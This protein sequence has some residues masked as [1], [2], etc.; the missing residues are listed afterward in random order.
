[1]LYD[2][3]KMFCPI[4]LL[5]T[6]EKKLIE[7]DIGERLQYQFIASNFIHSNQ[8]DRLKQHSTTNIGIV[9]THFICLGWIKGLQTSILV[10]NIVQFFLSLNYQL[11][12]LILNKAGFDSRISSF[13]SN[14]LIDRKTQYM[15]KNFISPFFKTDI[16]IG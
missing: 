5:N 10:F 9:L 6:L 12:S 13:F 16:G 2:F 8:L 15:W 11:L 1:M 14:Y 7:N 4:V 3:P